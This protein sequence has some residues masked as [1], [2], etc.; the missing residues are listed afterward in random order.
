MPEKTKYVIV[1]KYYPVEG[2]PVYDLHVDVVEAC[3]RKDALDRSDLT[4]CWIVFADTEEMFFKRYRDTK[5]EIEQ[6]PIISIPPS[7]IQDAVDIGLIRYFDTP[8]N[9][10]IGRLP[11]IA[12][13][14]A[15]ASL[16]VSILNFVMR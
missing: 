13:W 12:V 14:F 2:V 10:L 11:W 6:K 16:L 15:L 8:V 4:K 5:D 1:G 7:D 9:F 3:D